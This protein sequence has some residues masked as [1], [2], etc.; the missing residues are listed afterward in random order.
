MTDETTK[1]EDEQPEIKAD[2]VTEGTIEADQI[3]EAPFDPDADDGT[4]T[5]QGNEEV[6][7]AAEAE[8][9]QG[10]ATPAIPDTTAEVNQAI[11]DHADARSEGPATAEDIPPDA[12]A[13]L[14]E[15]AEAALAGEEPAPARSRDEL[16][17]DV[18]ERIL[19]DNEAD[20]ARNANVVDRDAAARAQQQRVIDAAAL[21]KAEAD[22]AK[23]KNQGQG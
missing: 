15:E 23:A 21:E 17:D 18:R 22:L 14:R 1:T 13:E 5:D 19:R 3:V 12:P 20:R 7:D 16:P 9:A 6:D 2:Q 8:A 4:S 10:S 11:A